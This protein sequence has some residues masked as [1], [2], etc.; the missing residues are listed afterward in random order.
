MHELVR[1][2]KAA[3]RAYYQEDHEIMSNLEYDKLYDELLHLEKETGVILAGSPTQQVGYEIVSALQ[4]ASH[5]IPMLSLD[6]TK[7]PETLS[8]F[9]DGQEGLLSWKL[10]GLTI[11]LKYD[12]GTLQ[13]A[14]T[15]GNGIIGEDVTH[16]AK[17]FANIPLNV[18]YM[19]KFELR[20]EAVI[21]LSDFEAINIEEDNKYKNPRNLCSGA[22]RQLNS[23][24]AAK[25][26]VLFYAFELLSSDLEVSLQKNKEE[27]QMLA[28]EVIA[29]KKSS[30]LNWLSEMGFSIVEFVFV[31]AETVAEEVAKFKQQISNAPLASDGLVLTYNDISYSKSLGTTSKFPKDSLAFKWADE[32]AETTLLS[33]EWGTSRTGLINPVAIFE[34]VDIEGTQVSRASLHNVSILRNL[35]LCP[36]DRITIYKANMIIPQVSENLTLNERKAT[37]PPS[38]PRNVEI[39]T[40]CSVCNGETEVIGNPE[41]LYCTNPNCEAQQVRAL[42]HFVSRDALNIAGLS[43]QTLEKFVAKGFVSDYTNLFDL[44]KYETEIVEMEGFGRRSYDKLIKAIEKAKD[45]ALPNFIYALG[46]RNVGLSNAKLLC[47]HFENN[48]TQIVETCRD[49]NYL[50]ILS[51]IKGFGEVISHSLHAYFIQDKNLELFNHTLTLLQI[52]TPAKLEDQ[53]L[54]GFSFVITGDVS[55]FPNR[56]A[57]QTFIE[58]RG[59]RVSSSVTSKISFLINN[60]S[61]SNSG[62]NKKAMQLEVPILTEDDFLER[63]MRT[64][65]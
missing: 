14:I 22:V 43:E 31:T 38:E 39:P 15:R 42:S 20:G 54:S 8:T 50:E 24:T 59:G 61:T 7:S 41:T 17:V 19:G 51:E 63:F 60:D 29:N 4:K 23:E 58:S 6:K 11:V 52:K 48:P 65:E 28:D 16:N 36:N 5:D 37:E 55:H 3:N 40:S 9:L 1:Q 46:I 2:L 62:K 47:T 45:I 34:P 12:N 49:N 10:D 64:N 13:Q 53:S 57:L 25:R 27:A 26:R 18:P 21:P 30:Q 32:L 56:K 44:S 33:I 35:E